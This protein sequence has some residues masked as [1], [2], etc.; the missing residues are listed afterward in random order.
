MTVARVCAMAV[1]RCRDIW[2]NMQRECST[3][4]AV[5]AGTEAAITITIYDPEE[6]PDLYDKTFK[7]A[8]KFDQFMSRANIG[9][10]FK[11]GNGPGVD[12]F[13]WATLVLR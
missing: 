9:S 5:Y 12:D 3:L 4:P 11:D 2:R 13:R 10:L 1:A 7:N 8:Q 6:K